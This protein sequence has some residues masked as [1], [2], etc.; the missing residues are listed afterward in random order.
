MPNRARVA[1]TGLLLA[2]ALAACQSP[3][4]REYEYE[5]QLYLS[6]D[7]SANVILSS[8][9]PAL[10]ALRG[11]PLDPAP[12]S[13]VD[14]AEVRAVFE[15]AGC[16]VSSVGAPWRRDGRRFIQVRMATDDVRTLSSCGVLSWSTYALTS[17]MG[18]ED[19]ERLRYVQTVGPPAAGNPGDVNWDGSEVVGFKLHLPSRIEFHNV[20]RLE[21]GSPGELERGN[22]L[23]WEQRLAD[24]R[25]GTPIRMEVVMGADSILYQTLLLFGVAFAAAVSLLGLAIWLTVRRGRK[26][27]SQSRKDAKT[28]S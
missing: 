7:G 5:E 12:S 2:G 11:V 28:P 26:R 10:V 3:L 1:V 6:V 16:P 13:R 19:G 17:E 25:A 14:Q 27:A 8:S 20:R 18:D 24:R 23:S 4:G 9:I 22:I 15:A 21:D